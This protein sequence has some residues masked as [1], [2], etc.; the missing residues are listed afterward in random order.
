MLTDFSFLDDNLAHEIVIDNPKI[1]ADMVDII[2]VIIETGGIPF[3]PK[4][5]D[6]KKEVYDLVFKKAHELYG[7]PLPTN[8]EKRIAQELYG[9][10][11]LNLVREKVLKENV[12][13]EEEKL[14]TIFIEELSS[15]VRK[16][17]DEVFSL[18]KDK[19]KEKNPNY[20]DKDLDKE[21]KKSLGG[22][23]GGGF[24]VIYLI[25]QKLVKHS[26]EEG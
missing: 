13:L 24:D 20:S 26:N 22:I 5:G 8:I 17:Y 18:T 2:E 9:D 15:I 19:I 4:M 16:G 11:I 12:G 7:D 14:E 23:I 3:S 1:I 25:A 6:S 21:T 10:G